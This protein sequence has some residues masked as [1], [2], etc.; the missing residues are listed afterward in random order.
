MLKSVQPEPSDNMSWWLRLFSLGLTLTGQAFVGILYALL[1][2]ALVTS[3]FQF[4]NRHLPVPQQNHVVLI[5]LSR[6]GQKVAAVLQELNQPFVGVHT[7][8]LGDRVLPKMP[9]IIDNPTEAL[10]LVNLTHAK[11]IVLV[12]DDRMENLE[13]G[14]MAHAINPTSRLIIRSQ[15]R[16]FSENIASLFPYAQVVCGAALSAEVFACA[17]FGENVLSLFHLSAQIVNKS[18]RKSQTFF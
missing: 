2:D 5:G 6:L 18:Y 16:Q 12:G 4:F 13:I 15:D 7:T 17:A 11:S 14:L 1:T 3:K 10:A 9:L 8:T